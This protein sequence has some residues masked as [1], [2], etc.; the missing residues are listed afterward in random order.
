MIAETTGRLLRTTRRLTA[1][2]GLLVLSAGAAAAAFGAVPIPPADV[3]G[4]SA[5]DGRIVLAQSSADVA[6]QSMRIDRLEDQMR[7]L[8]GRIDEMTYSLQQIQQLL[9]RM[10]EDNE[11]RFQELEKGGKPRKKSEAPAAPGTG[12]FAAA[13]LGTGTPPSGD[14][15]S[16]GTPDVPADIA[17]GFSIEPPLDGGGAPSD[18]SGQGWGAPPANLGNL[19]ADGGF[20][21]GGGAPLDLSAIARGDLGTSSQPLPPAGLPGVS[22]ATDPAPGLPPPVA[23]APLAPPPGLATPPPSDQSEVRVASLG[24]G[25]EDARAAY[26]RAYGYVVSGDYAT[27][28]ESLK[29][30]LADHP[31]DKLAG[32]ARFWLGE[33][34]YA[35]G[36]YRDA[37]DAFLT[38][39][40]DYP[41]NPKA[42]DSLLKLGL[43]LEGLG[44]TE[45]ACAT[46]REV[47]KKFPG[48][49]GALLGKVSAQKSKAGC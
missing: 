12:D 46:Y 42:P 8:N 44:E 29:R 22:G 31:R 33:T 1:A 23:S 34:Y 43:S 49:S 30:F 19:P 15:L 47:E 35:R 27:A 20:S 3:P 21:G 36:N 38:T 41:K 6:Q 25:Q 11:F 13:D 17:A 4:G 9:Q 40:R 14:V 2:A 7:Q 16:T 28:E 39:Y 26:D 18:G 45:A 37:A 10:Q 48:A 32:N 24:N 5:A